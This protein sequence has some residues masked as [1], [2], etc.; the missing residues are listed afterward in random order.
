LDFLKS[1]LKFWEHG[2]KIKFPA[3]AEASAPA[4][5]VAKKAPVPPVRVKKEGS[6]DPRDAVP[7]RWPWRS[8]LALFF[9]LLGQRAF[10]P[11]PDRKATAGLVLYAFGVAW[12][13]VAY[14]RKEWTLSP[15]P[16]EGRGS[17]RMN[18]RLLPLALAIPLAVSAFLTMGGNLFTAVNVTLWVGAILCTVWAFWLPGPQARTDR[19]TAV[20]GGPVIK[21][22]VLANDRLQ[23]KNASRSECLLPPRSGAP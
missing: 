16:E 22:D 4:P 10:E 1:Q 12:L 9:A 15:L 17:G 2:D 18:V 8:L 20:E 11:S 21:G 13:V 23:G 6:S 14:L 7:N 3:A 5:V 19:E